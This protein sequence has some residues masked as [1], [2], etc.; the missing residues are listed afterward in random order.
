MGE[1]QGS[2]KH[3]VTGER[4]ASAA[5]ALA[6]NQGL[7]GVSMRK[8]GSQLGVEAMSLYYHLPSKAALLDAMVD[9]LVKNLPRLNLSRGW[10]ACFTSAAIAWRG[11]ATE[12][13]GAFPLVASRVHACPL[14]LDKKHGLVEVL[15]QAGAKPL[16]AGHLATSFVVAL[17]GFLLA[18]NSVVSEPT[19]EQRELT[20]KATTNPDDSLPPAAWDL[21]ADNAFAAHVAFLLDA[22]AAALA[23]NQRLPG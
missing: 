13:P 3:P 11:I 16:D 4:I 8:I 6:D 12:H 10:R 23:R 5:I 14:L 20:P 22:I 17:N 1:L 2:A 19:K 15:A 7:S 18:A 21:T 9:E